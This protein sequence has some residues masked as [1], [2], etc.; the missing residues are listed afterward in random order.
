MSV[1]CRGIWRLKRGFVPDRWLQYARTGSGCL[2]AWRGLGC[3]CMD[4]LRGQCMSRIYGEEERDI[5]Y[6]FPTAWRVEEALRR[7]WRMAMRERSRELYASGLPRDILP[8]WMLGV[9]DKLSS[10]MDARRVRMLR[11]PSTI[12]SC[13]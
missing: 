11:V 8:G 1:P 12:Q 13:Q 5:T 9:W 7:E 4:V 10:V 2:C 6:Q 3:T